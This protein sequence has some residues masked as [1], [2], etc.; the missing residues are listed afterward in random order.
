MK[1]IIIVNKN[2]YEKTLGNLKKDGV[3][4]LHILSDFDRTLTKAFVD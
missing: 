2:K 1:N 4:K 3:D